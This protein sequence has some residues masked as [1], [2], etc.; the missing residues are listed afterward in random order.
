MKLIGIFATLVVGITLLLSSTFA[1]AELTY[2]EE[3]Y[4]TEVKRK[5]SR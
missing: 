5:I 1:H 3:G 2:A 4:Q